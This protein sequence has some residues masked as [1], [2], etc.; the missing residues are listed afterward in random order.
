MESLT[1]SEIEDGIEFPRVIKIE[2]HAN[3]NIRSCCCF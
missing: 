3:N 2:S 1:D